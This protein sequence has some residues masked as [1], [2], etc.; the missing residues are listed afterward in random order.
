MVNFVEGTVTSGFIGTQ[1]RYRIH[2]SPFIVLYYVALH[3]RGFL[4]IIRHQYD[5]NLNNLVG[6]MVVRAM[7]KI[8]VIWDISLCILVYMCRYQPFEMS[9]HS[10]V[11]IVE[12]GSPHDGGS[13]ILQNIG[14]FVMIRMLHYPGKRESSNGFL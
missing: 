12:K 8:P 1:L 13:E 7:L 5:T 4:L 3:D 10:I 9:C 14:T 6:F 2:I 11:R